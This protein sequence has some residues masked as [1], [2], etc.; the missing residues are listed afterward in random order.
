MLSDRAMY[1]C[2]AV[3]S[4]IATLPALVSLSGL[5]T[6]CRAL[7]KMGTLTAIVWIVFFLGFFVFQAWRAI[8]IKKE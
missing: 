3:F 5:P 2:G 8:K 6:A 1:V 4:L 7:C